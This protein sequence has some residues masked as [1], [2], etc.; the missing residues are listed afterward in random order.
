MPLWQEGEVCRFKADM[1]YL[2][3]IDHF[4]AVHYNQEQGSRPGLGIEIIVR[5]LI[6]SVQPFAVEQR[7]IQLSESVGYEQLLV[8]L[9]C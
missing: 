1:G 2:R 9:F 6:N 7:S 3:H 5:T 4:C 8:Y